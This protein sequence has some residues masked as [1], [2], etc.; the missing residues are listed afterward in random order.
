MITRII[1]WKWKNRQKKKSK[2]LQ[3]FGIF[4]FIC[5]F[6]MIIYTYFD[7][8]S[9]TIHYKRIDSSNRSQTSERAKKKKL[10]EQ[11]QNELHMSFSLPKKACQNEMYVE[12]HPLNWYGVNVRNDSCRNGI[13]AVTAAATKA[14]A[15]GWPFTESIPI[16]RMNW[17]EQ[18]IFCLFS[19]RHFPNF[20]NRFD[21]C[22]VSDYHFFNF[23]Q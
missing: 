8:I 15:C 12:I 21:C 1:I 17:A 7:I 5:H 22:A 20:A 23:S 9:T 6:C 3:L 14:N 16:F 11:K 4:V 13:I 2:Y 19:C 10:N 18:R